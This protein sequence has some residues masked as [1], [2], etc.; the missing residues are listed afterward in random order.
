M[1]RNDANRLPPP[2]RIQSLGLIPTGL[3]LCGADDCGGEVVVV[4]SVVALIWC[5]IVKIRV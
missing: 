3:I 5:Q 4:W 1:N 2:R